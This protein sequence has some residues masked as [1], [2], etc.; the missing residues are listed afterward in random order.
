MI[1]SYEGVR[2][3]LL[4]RE[5]KTEQEAFAEMR[6]FLEVNNITTIKESARPIIKP[7]VTFL[8]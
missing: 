6:R 5:V 2:G 4:L 8:L 7:L 3:G 1:V